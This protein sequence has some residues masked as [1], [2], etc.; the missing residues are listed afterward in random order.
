[1]THGT[2]MI[3]DERQETGDF[4]GVDPGQPSRPQRQNQ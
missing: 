1:M 3:E 4:L 2:L